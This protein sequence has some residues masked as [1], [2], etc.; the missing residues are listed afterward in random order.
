MPTVERR[1]L[2]NGIEVA[3][4]ENHELPVVSVQT[5]VE[6]RG[7]LDPVDKDGLVIVLQ[8]ML[9]EGT[10]SMTADQLAEAFADLGNSVSPTSFTTITRNVDRSLALMADMLTHPAFPQPALDRIRANEIASLKRLQDQP[11]YI[12]SRVFNNIVYGHGHP[13]ERVR[14]EATLNAITRADLL[15]FHDTYYRPQN[16]KVVVAGDITPRDAVAKL[17]KTFGAW[18]KGG[19]QAVYDIAPAKG[20][21]T[22]TIYLFDR[23]NSPQ[24]VVQVGQLG[25]RRDTPDYFADELLNTALGG[26]FNS[27]INLNLRERHAYTYGANSGFVYRRVPEIGSF[28]AQTSVVTAKTDSALVELMRELRDIR[29]ARPVTQTELDFARASATLSLP[30]RLETLTSMT[31]AVAAILRDNLAPDYY[32]RYSANMAKVTTAD[33]AAA[34]KAH[35]DPEHMAIVVVGDRKQIEA[36]LRA[37]NIAPIIVVD[38]MAKPVAPPM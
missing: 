35:I 4:L 14:T 33:V 6:A 17:E 21:G 9:S 8:Q 32:D 36:G 23:P 11:Q 5:V 29:G 2:S 37:A 10:T 25:P 34:A 38:E 13:Y 12:A 15:S 3:I 16:V 18:P 19:K 20:P 24:S 22:T 7:T 1:T 31:S 27:R 30:M 28:Q 26:I